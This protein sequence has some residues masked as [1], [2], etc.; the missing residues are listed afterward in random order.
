MP[1]YLL[2]APISQLITTTRLQDGQN[3]VDEVNFHDDYDLG[4]VR[5]EPEVE[6]KFE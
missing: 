5:K 4:L 1:P 3:I 2:N 6:D